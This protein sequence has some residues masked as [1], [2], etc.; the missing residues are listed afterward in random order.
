MPSTVAPFRLSRLM[1]IAGSS[2]AGYPSP[3][4]RFLF[5]FLATVLLAVAV[6]LAVLDAT[7]SVAM[8]RLVLTPLGESWK[9]LSPATLESV[10]T[11]LEA[12][13]P[14]LWDIVGVWLLSMPG[15]ILFA[16]LA[17]LLYAVGHRPTRHGDFAA[18]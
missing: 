3:M 6:I 15:S 2:L 18:E 7:R 14:P 17:L 4:V 5:R 13:W 1:R 11:A 9:A 10:R 8:S 16:V 12:R